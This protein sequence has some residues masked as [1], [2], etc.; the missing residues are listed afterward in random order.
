VRARRPASIAAFVLATVVRA[1][2][3]CE[4]DLAFAIPELERVAGALLSA[5]GIDWRKETEPLLRDAKKVASVEEHYEMLRRLVARLQD[6]HADVRKTEKTK[7]FAPKGPRKVV[8]G[9]S[10]CRGARDSVLLVNPNDKAGGRG[11]A[12][13]LEVVEIGGKDAVAWLK[14]RAKKL[15][16]TEPFSSERHAFAY[17]ATY[18]LAEPR[19]TH[20]YAREADVPIGAPLEIDGLEG[21]NDVRFKKLESG[22]GYVQIRRC[23]G[24]LPERLDVAFRTV[25]DA[26]GLIL[27]LRGNSG[28]G[29]DHDDLMGRFVPKGTKMAF[30]GRKHYASTGD[31]PFKGDVVVIVDALVRSAG[32]T[33][34]AIFK[35]DGRGY[36]V[37]DS[38]TAG[39][40]SQKTTVAL[41]GGYFDLYVSTGS[42]M[43]R[44]AGGK[45][46]E[47]V[48]VEPH[49]I[50]AYETKDLL[51][52]V[53]TVLKRAE[54]ILAAFP[55]S[56]IPYSPPK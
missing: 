28:G 47:G 43:S 34:A 3:P 44:A 40:S 17:A 2:N 48:G 53:D 23:V 37:G 52:G 39:M 8:P 15:A 7:D 18:G 14:A 56:A 33:L 31:A 51:A 6:G 49:E 9:F 38:A 41:P 21:G 25:G 30:K 5:K 32:E 12:T 26:K 27:D 24:D 42:N 11:A 19:R 45:G 22:F 36:L 55:R 29:F 1:Q 4:V 54:A 10:F 16:D 50:V 13:G 20:V 46:I 35:E